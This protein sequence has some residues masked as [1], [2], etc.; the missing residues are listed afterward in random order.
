MDRRKVFS[1][2][3]YSMNHVFRIKP[4]V[5]DDLKVTVNNFAS[6]MDPDLIRNVCGSTR[7]RLESMAV[8][9]I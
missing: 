2:W 4:E 1:F 6:A 3:G 9:S 7:N 8:G 5:M